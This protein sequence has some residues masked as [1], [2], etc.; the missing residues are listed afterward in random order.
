MLDFKQLQ[1]LN[2]IYVYKNFTRASE[3]LYVSQP[4]I[5][6]S[7]KRMEE[8]LGFKLLDRNSKNVSFTAE[9][10]EFMI[11]VKQ[12]L[13]LC[14]R[15]EDVM[16]DLA[17][18]SKQKIRLG[19]SPCM[20]DP[21]IPLI[22]SDFLEKNPEAQISLDEG[23]TQKHLSML[24]NNL[25]D[26]TFNG[27]PDEYSPD[28][29]R[30]IPVSQTEIHA[31][32]HPS[33]PL[34]SLKRIPIKALADEKL[35]MMDAQ[36]RVRSMMVREFERKHVVP[37]IVTSY[38]QIACM[39]NIV[40]RCRYVGILSIAKGKPALGCAGLT[41][42]PFEEPVCFDIGFSMMKEKHISKLTHKLIDFIRDI[43][44]E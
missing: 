17:N 25:L 15:T 32:L 20:C 28:L 36:S 1:Y 37:N 11:W 18:A 35:I 12:I 23:S 38:D 5:S 7:I 13:A 34:A 43:Y 40:E 29:Y 22:F 27:L 3:V 31:V 9:G 44:V 26:L 30:T 21:T 4:A 14:D 8:D 16:K 33:H 10:E 24:E 19:I 42:L 2:A 6:A 41:V 39:A